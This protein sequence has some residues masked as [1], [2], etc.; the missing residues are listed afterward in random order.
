MLTGYL[1]VWVA[2]FS[3]AVASSTP[4]AASAA[5]ASSAGTIATC[6]FPRRVSMTAL[7]R[8]RTWAAISER[9]AR[10]D[11]I[12]C[13][14]TRGR[15]TDGLPVHRVLLYS[16]DVTNTKAHTTKCLRCDRTL[17]C[18]ASI[19]AGYGRICRA[20]ILAAAIT[21]ALQGYSKTQLEKALEAL[22]DGALIRVRQGL[23]QAVSSDGQGQ[24]LTST[25][26]CDCPAGQHGRTC[27][28]TAAA[29]M[30]GA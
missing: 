25:D 29:R 17:R 19:T 10:A 30:I 23:W 20:R 11:A 22:T 18:Q 15:V 21:K 28:H 8:R 6:G 27:Y 4:P 26:T 5:S 3:A 14:S 13:S 9:L 2:R 12:G 16:S 7:R 24:Y 1:G